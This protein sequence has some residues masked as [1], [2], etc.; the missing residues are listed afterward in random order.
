MLKD[1][2]TF[3]LQII[4]CLRFSEH[5]GQPVLTETE[6]SLFPQFK[7]LLIFQS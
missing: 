2:V 7:G 5:G 6:R 1:K 4:W 3:S